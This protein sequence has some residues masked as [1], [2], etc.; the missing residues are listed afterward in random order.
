LPVAV[1]KIERNSNNRAKVLLPRENSS[2]GG[3]SRENKKTNYHY[4]KSLA[5]ALGKAIDGE[6]SISA[7]PK[8]DQT[9]NGH[10]LL[11]V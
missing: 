6:L 7:W 8:R 3:T 4:I 9:P 2:V 5:T 11:G 1:Y 10:L